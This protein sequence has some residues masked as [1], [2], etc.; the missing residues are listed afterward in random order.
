MINIAQL[1]KEFLISLYT[2]FVNDLLA[3]FLILVGISWIVFTTYKIN[4]IAGNYLLGAILL[5]IG[6]LIAKSKT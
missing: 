2:V 5:L 4:I 1:I 3:D 6:I